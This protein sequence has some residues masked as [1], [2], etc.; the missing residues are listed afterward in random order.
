M[1]LEYSESIPELSCARQSIDADFPP[2][3]SVLGRH[4]GIVY[5]KQELRELLNLHARAG[6]HGGDLQDGTVTMAQGALDLQDKVVRDSMTPAD[7]VSPILVKGSSPVVEWL[8]LA[9]VFV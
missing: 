8:T 7:D 4:N 1:L 5:R 3:L 2:S 6:H 9:M